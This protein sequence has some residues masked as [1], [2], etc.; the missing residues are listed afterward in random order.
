[1]KLSRGAIAAYVAV[2]FLCGAVLGAFS[3]RL[4]TVSTVSAKSTK[5][6]P[7]PEQVR[8]DILA[9]M[10]S[11]LKLTDEQVTKVNLIMDD[12]RARIRE[13]HDRSNPQIQEIRKEQTDKI[14]A[15]L[16][17]DQRST[18]EEMLKQREQR[19]R[20]KGS[21]GGGPGF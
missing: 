19:Q 20:E 5:R 3:F 4:Y 17:A 12:T 2:V 8:K 14:R 21:R 11:N 10:K 7:N 13:V 16:S 18:Y 1:M 6:P 15:L 9:F